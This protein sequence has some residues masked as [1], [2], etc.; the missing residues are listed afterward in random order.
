MRDP[1]HPS[2][3]FY[4]FIK[5]QSSL[6]YTVFPCQSLEVIEC[7]IFSLDKTRKILVEISL[8]L[9]YVLLMMNLYCCLLEKVIAG[10]LGRGLMMFVTDVLAPPSEV[11]FSAEN[12]WHGVRHFALVM[13]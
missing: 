3:T 8:H 12:N 1:I 10:L 9:F 13:R 7:Y 6:P 5:V 2:P 11:I 4:E